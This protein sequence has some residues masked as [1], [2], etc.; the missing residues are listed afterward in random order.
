MRYEIG[1]LI[2]L[3]LYGDIMF[4]YVIKTRTDSYYTNMK[5]AI[6]NNNIF[7]DNETFLLPETHEGWSLPT[8]EEIRTVNKILTFG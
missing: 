3:S 4:G 6:M 1:Q 8:E 7:L 5:I 2:K